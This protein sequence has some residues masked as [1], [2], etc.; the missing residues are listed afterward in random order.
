[1]SHVSLPQFLAAV[2]VL[3]ASRALATDPQLV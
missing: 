1:V 2:A 3:V